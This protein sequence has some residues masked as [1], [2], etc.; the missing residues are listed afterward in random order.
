MSSRFIYSRLH[1]KPFWTNVSLYKNIT[2]SNF[3]DHNWQLRN[4]LD[5]KKIAHQPTGSTQ[6]WSDFQESQARSTMAVKV[7]PY[8]ASLIDWNDPYNCP[9]RKQFVPVHSTVEPDHPMLKLDSLNEQSDSPVPGLIHRYPDKVLFLTTSTC[10]V[11]CRFCTRSY[12]IGTN[13]E[14]VKNKVKFIPG[15]SRFEK[16]YQYIEKHGEIEDVVV[17]GGDTYLLPGHVLLELGKRLLSIDHVRRIRCA[18]KGLSAMP[19]KILTDHKW[20]ESV[21]T[22]SRVARDMS[23][24]FAIHT[25]IN[26]PSEI[27]YV[28][29]DAADK[30]FKANIHVRNQCVLLHG[31]NDNFQTMHELIK[32]LAYINIQPYYVYLHDMVAGAEEFRTTLDSAIELE[33]ELRGSTAGFNMPQFIVD[34]PYGGGKRLVSSYEM[35]DRD[36]GISVFRSP[37]IEE[38]RNAGR[39][40]RKT[41]LFFLL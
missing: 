36:T 25:H 5:A 18:T 17:S 21:A 26:H 3:F 32:Y 11:Y 14:G 6:F 19:M 16:I 40:E 4:T 12:S 10:P 28:T 27:T 29:K 41:D 22:L 31:I 15:K 1:P 33:K 30:L 2:E 35:Y 37:R 8:I 38:R 23:K 7:T 20:F 39:H 9:V 24:S 34:L 13:T